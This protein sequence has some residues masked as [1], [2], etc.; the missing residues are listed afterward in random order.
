MWLRESQQI[1][2]GGTKEHQVTHEAS[3]ITGTL[4]S[5]PTR[6]Q[7]SPARLSESTSE[8]WTLVAFFFPHKFQ[9]SLHSDPRGSLPLPSS[10]NSVPGKGLPAW[11]FPSIQVPTSSRPKG[12]EDQIPAP[13]AAT[14]QPLRR[15]PW[16]ILLFS[17]NAL[18]PADVSLLP[19]HPLI[20]PWG[21][22]HP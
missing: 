17:T 8:L 7:F 21:T 12:I 10:G 4:E 19:G 5:S 11:G 2:D 20:S 9:G 22:H 18:L 1:L 6:H 13:L 16:A 3:V 14:P 15:L